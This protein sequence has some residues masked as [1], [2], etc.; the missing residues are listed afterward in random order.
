MSNE[1]RTVCM[2][3]LIGTPSKEFENPRLQA[4]TD[5]KELSQL[6]ESYRN[7]DLYIKKKVKMEHS[8][9]MQFQNKFKNYTIKNGIFETKAPK[10][11]FLKTKTEVS[12]PCTYGEEFEIFRMIDEVFYEAGKI[13]SFYNTIPMDCFRKEVRDLFT[14]IHLHDI[15]QFYTA[16][17]SNG[18]DIDYYL[19]DGGVS[20]FGILPQADIRVDQLGLFIYR[21]GNLLKK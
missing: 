19:M 1:E 14:K 10:D 16:S 15:Y 9:W 20:D 5:K 8:E 18:E 12:I 7:M 4:F 13:T 21:F 6:W 3:Y 11:S 2:Y 17:F